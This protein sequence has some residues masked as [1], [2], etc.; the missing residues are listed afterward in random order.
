MSRHPTILKII[1]RP[2]HAQNENPIKSPELPDPRRPLEQRL[3]EYTMHRSKIFGYRLKPGTFNF[4]FLPPWIWYWPKGPDL[5]HYFH[6]NTIQK[7]SVG[8]RLAHSGQN[9]INKG[10]RLWPVGVWVYS[11]LL[12][13]TPHIISIYASLDTPHSN[14]PQQRAL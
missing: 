1:Q 4:H 10:Q 12:Q 11:T 13:L 7:K 14:T 6:Q 9:N 3:A 8:S 2:H 5:V